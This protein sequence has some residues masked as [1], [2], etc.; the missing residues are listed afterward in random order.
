MVLTN[1]NGQDYKNQVGAI[2][3]KFYFSDSDILSYQLMYSDSNNPDAIRYD[4]DDDDTE[5]LAASQNDSAIR[6]EYQHNEDNYNLEASYQDFGKDFRADMGFIGMVDYRKLR[7]GGE[8]IWYGE[9]NS[10]W[11]QWSIFG[12]IDRTDDQSDKKLEEEIEL[13]FNIRGPMQ[14]DANLGVVSRERYFDGSYFDEVQT[15]VFFEFKPLSSL[16]IGSY[17]KV[18]DQVDFEHT[19]AGK[20][21]LYEPFIEWQVSQ[22]F[23]IELEYT[24]NKLSVEAGELFY[25]K[26]LDLRLAYQFNIRSRLSLALLGVDIDKNLD[27][28][29]NNFDNDPDNDVLASSK[30]VGSQLI[31]SYKLNPQTLFYMGYSD[32]VTKNDRVLS[33]E[34]TDKTYFAKFSYMWQS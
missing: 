25:A 20:M 11:T 30:T 12:D 2:D 8:Y 6:L 32:K 33:L 13:H 22:H 26:L 5:V 1:R 27:L 7:L 21:K 29:E 3:G 15:L 16:L 10:S 23:N 17:I 18:G 14:F 19:Q 34:K 31:Y 28:Y 4:E 24:S 9:N